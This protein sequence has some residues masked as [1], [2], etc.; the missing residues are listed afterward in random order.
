MGLQVRR[1]V[2]RRGVAGLPL[3]PEDRGSTAPG[4]AR[5]IR[6]SN[7]VARHHLTDAAGNRV[8]TFPAERTVLQQQFLDLLALP[9]PAAT[10]PSTG[11]AEAPP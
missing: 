4:A 9:A 6:V 2:N 5:I 3:Y 8:Q 10:D 7:G 11:G 1:E